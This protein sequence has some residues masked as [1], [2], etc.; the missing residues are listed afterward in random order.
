MSLLTNFDTTV[1]FWELYPQLK[2]PKAFAELYKKDK[3]KGHSDSSQIMW[4]V[5]MLVDVSEDNKFSHLSEE[6]R[7]YL[8]KEDY[9]E[10]PKFKFEDYKDVV[11]MYIHLHMSKLEQELR[12]QEAK[13]E[14]RA[15]FIKD[16]I[17][18]LETGEKLDK[19]LLN[20]AKLYDNIKE[21]KDR[22]KSEKDSG[23]IRG[24]RIES[25]SEK[26]LI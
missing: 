15:L 5:A 22:I 13:M 26:G 12:T 1:N 23:S 3:S 9:L 8:I 16:T 24:G 14:E 17:Y 11:D 4:A 19:F 2:I 25:A 6:D 20:T 7:K 10:N 18:D 21:L